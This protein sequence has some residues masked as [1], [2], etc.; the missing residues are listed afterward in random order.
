LRRGLN[1]IPLTESL[2]IYNKKQ[3]GELAAKS[4]NMLNEITEKVR[5][6]WN[7][8]DRLIGERN[9]LEI[10]KEECVELRAQEIV[11]SDF[12]KIALNTKRI[13]ISECTSPDWKNALDQLVQLS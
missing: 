5:S 10:R 12:Q 11:A 9:F 4:M 6:T 2:Y 13:S 7:I 1:E 3:L 8:G